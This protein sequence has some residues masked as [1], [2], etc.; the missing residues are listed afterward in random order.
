MNRLAAKKLEDWKA[1]SPLAVPDMRYGYVI[2]VA[3][4]AASHWNSLILAAERGDDA[5]ML[6]HGSQIKVLTVECL[7]V[8]REMTGKGD[9]KD[10]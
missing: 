9:G 10:V 3:E 5:L 2:D 4:H 8:I 6:L 7:R 1:V